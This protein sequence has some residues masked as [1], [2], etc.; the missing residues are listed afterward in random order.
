MRAIGELGE[1]GHVLH[2]LGMSGPPP[3]PP[4]VLAMLSDAELAAQ[5]RAL[6]AEAA[7]R[8]AADR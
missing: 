1:G 3:P 2:T 6:Q 7:R 8:Q 5:L 4:A